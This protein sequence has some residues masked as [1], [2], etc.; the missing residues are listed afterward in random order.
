MSD[1]DTPTAP[2]PVQDI[3]QS[4]EGLRRTP[5]GAFL[6]GMIQRGLKRFGGGDA[7]EAGFL[8]FLY[9]LLG[10][11]SRDAS[12]NP[13]T[14]VK[15]RLIQQHLAV[16]LPPEPAAAAHEKT[17]RAHRARPES[18]DAAR[19]P[20][21]VPSA[22]IP[23][24][25]VEEAN[26]QQTADAGIEVSASRSVLADEPQDAAIELPVEGE[27]L[28]VASVPLGPIEIERHAAAAVD[29]M[30]HLQSE[31]AQAI[32]GTIERNDE[33]AGLLRSNLK[34]LKLADNGEDLLDLK[35]LLVKGLEELLSDHNLLGGELVAAD[36]YLKAVQR[37]Q[38][39][40]QQQMEDISKHSL[41]DEV[42]GL[43]KR[44]ALRVRVAAETSRAQRYGFSLAFALVDIDGMAALNAR[45]G[46]DFGDEVLRHYAREVLSRFRSYDVVARYGDDEFAVLLPNTLKEGAQRALEKARDLVAGL[47]LSWRGQQ[48]ALPGFSSVLTMYSPGEDTDA[49]LRRAEEALGMARRKGQ[50]QSVVL[51]PGSA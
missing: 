46:R 2:G 38:A 22:S 43:I 49:L 48:I 11:Y 42:T 4:L 10:K 15:A 25:P 29:D 14:R 1:S 12:A 6:Y 21:E 35:R 31:L 44:E 5:D 36:S 32:A 26:P 30:E 8:R 34:A 23:R 37:D 20:E 27:L 50:N 41:S 3:L 39:I 45:H 18:Q 9:N 24:P 28:E 19:E 51:L 33:F 7:M 13:V 40:M 17:D 47:A 16:H